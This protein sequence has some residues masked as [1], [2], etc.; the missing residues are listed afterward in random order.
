MTRLYFFVIAGDFQMEKRDL[1]LNLE[2]CFYWAV[3][4]TMVVLVVIQP[5]C[6][7]QF[8]LCFYSLCNI[9][10]FHFIVFLMSTVI[11]V[12]R[13]TGHFTAN[14]SLCSLACWKLPSN[15]LSEWQRGCIKWYWDQCWGHNGG[16]II[17]IMNLFWLIDILTWILPSSSL[18]T[19]G[20]WSRL[21]Y[22]VSSRSGRNKSLW[23]ALCISFLPSSEVGDRF[24]LLHNTRLLRSDKRRWKLRIP[25]QWLAQTPQ[26]WVMEGW[27][28]Q[29]N[30][31]E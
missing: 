24:D 10:T 13:K 31:F 16:Q 3:I 15:T 25:G 12:F 29:C 2:K 11:F 23:P 22:W 26:I 9:Y 30:K 5:P 18:M 6:L 4:L 17:S 8:H 19:G 27:S 7:A 1:W 28:V 20:S 21:Y 14:W